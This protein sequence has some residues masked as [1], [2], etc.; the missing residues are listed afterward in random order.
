MNLFKKRDGIDLLKEKLEKAM[1]DMQEINSKLQ[2][3][4][5]AVH[6]FYTIIKALEEKKDE[7]P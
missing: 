6:E 1:K 7:S 5:K 3:T 2:D 4:Y